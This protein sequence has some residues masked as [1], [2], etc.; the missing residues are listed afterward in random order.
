MLSYHFILGI[1]PMWLWCIIVNRLLYLFCSHFKVFL[2][3]Y[4]GEVFFSNS[5]SSWCFLSHFHI[6]IMLASCCEGETIF[7]SSVFFL[8]RLWEELV[9]TMQSQ[10]GLKQLR[11]HACFKLLLELASEVILSWTFYYWEGFD[12]RR[13]SLTFYRCSHILYFFLES[14]SVICVFLGMYAFHLSY[15]IYWHII[16]HG[17]SL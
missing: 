14:V 6:R 12:Y 2:D 7:S 3:L 10:T 15:L 17:I 11:M 16:V 9:L 1:Y 8:G 5:L 4:S 13:N